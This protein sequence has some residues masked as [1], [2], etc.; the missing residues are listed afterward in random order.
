MK[1]SC[2]RLRAGGRLRPWVRCSSPP[3]LKHRVMSIMLSSRRPLHWWTLENSNSKINHGVWWDFIFSFSY[4][5]VGLLSA[6]PFSK[7]SWLHSPCG[8]VFTLSL[9]YTSRFPRVV[10]VQL[11]KSATVKLPSLPNPRAV[12]V[13]VGAE[14]VVG[15]RYVY[16]FS[17]FT[18][19]ICHLFFPLIPLEKINIQPWTWLFSTSTTASVRPW[20]EVFAVDF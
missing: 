6:P 4:R 18:P 10:G 8:G 13:R 12:A 11:F 2:Q 17:N 9:K 1:L 16:I 7:R 15:E 20:S 5:Y 14:E 19:C 3:V